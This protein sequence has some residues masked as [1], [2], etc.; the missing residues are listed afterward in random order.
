MPKTVLIILAAVIALIAIVV[1]TRDA[2]PA[3][4]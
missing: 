3:R 1:I 2:L 4:R